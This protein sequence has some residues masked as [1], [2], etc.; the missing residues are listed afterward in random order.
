MKPI[1]MSNT[2]DGQY[3]VKSDRTTHDALDILLY[4]ELGFGGRIVESSP[5]KVVVRTQVLGCVDLTTFEGE[6]SAMV[7]IQKAAQ[8]HQSLFESEP[9]NSLD[10]SK[11]ATFKE[12]TNAGIA[13]L[14]NKPI[15]KRILLMLLSEF[16]QHWPALVKQ[17]RQD[18]TIIADDFHFNRLSKQDVLTL[19][20]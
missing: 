19:I 18:L 3:E 10:V 11:N 15:I 13:L 8:I 1:K 9:T 7:L 14:S 2:R 5:T 6:E 12:F 20:S 4:C 17:S 16:E